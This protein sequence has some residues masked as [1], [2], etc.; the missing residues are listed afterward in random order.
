VIVLD[1]SAALEWLLQNPAAARV[2]HKLF[3]ARQTL[4]APY[5]IDLEVV[6]AMRKCLAAQMI[7]PQRA[8]EGLEIL[9]DLPITRHT[10]DGLFWRIWNLRDSLGAY[11][12]TYVAL[13]ESLG[14]TLITCDV[15]IRAASGH[16]ARVE[17]V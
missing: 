11:D 4:H 10:L 14:A 5:L 17:V 3:A 7:S 12:A 16:Y 13:A 6:Q 15:K 2:E 1:A 9:L 8:Q